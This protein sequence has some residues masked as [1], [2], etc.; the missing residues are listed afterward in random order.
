MPR[1]RAFFHRPSAEAQRDIFVLVEGFYNRARFHS[2]MGYLRPIQME[3]KATL[4]PSIFSTEDQVDC[5]FMS[6]I[7]WDL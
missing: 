3:L 2:A 4:N 7:V 6:K 1:G 5:F